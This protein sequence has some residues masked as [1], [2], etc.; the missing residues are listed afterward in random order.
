MSTLFEVPCPECG[1]Q[2][3]V[4]DNGRL[5]CPICRR[6]YHARMGHLFVV[7]EPPRASRGAPP[8]RPVTRPAT[9]AQS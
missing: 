3:L 4:H 9:P 2:M 1:R 8:P 5:E 7:N 6:A